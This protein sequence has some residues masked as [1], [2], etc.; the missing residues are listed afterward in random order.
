MKAL[1]KIKEVSD[2]L[3]ENGIEDAPAEAALLVAEL[4]PVGKARL[5]ADNPELPAALSAAVDAGAARRLKGEPLQYIIGHVP[6]HGLRINVGPGVL[7]PRPETELLVEETIKRVMGHGSRVMSYGEQG[8]ES[9]G[10]P[11]THHPS[12][13]AI[14]DLC[15]GSGCI[16]L[17]LAKHFPD[18]E[19]YGVDQSEAALVYATQNALENGIGNVHF[20]WGDL[21]DPVRSRQFDCIVSNPPYIARSEIATLQREVKEYEPYEALDGGPDGLEFYRKILGQ[22]PARLRE[23]GILVLEMGFGQA[24]SVEAM[25]VKAGL[26][27]IETVKDYA[28][29]ERIII[30]RRH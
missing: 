16:A 4:L 28:G 8:S 25:A 21:F 30:G 7:I 19:V 11:V 26:S 10:L 23:N 17:A 14:L 12:P 5:Y 18:A 29:I 20:R 15:T 9:D 1:Q 22:A 3:E 2:V 24:R 27:G 13:S 6:F